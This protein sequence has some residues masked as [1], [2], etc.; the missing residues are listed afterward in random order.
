MSCDRLESFNSRYL[1]LLDRRYRVADVHLHSLYFCVQFQLILLYVV[2]SVCGLQGLSMLTG[3]LVL[4]KQHRLMLFS[5]ST[6]VSVQ[7]TCPYH[8]VL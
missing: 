3:D 4:S 1:Q 7:L 5:S 8:T 6:T 2:Q